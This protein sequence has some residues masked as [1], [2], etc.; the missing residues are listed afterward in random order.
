MGHLGASLH[1]DVAQVGLCELDELLGRKPSRAPFP[2]LV[3]QRVIHRRQEQ[4]LKDELGTLLHGY[5]Q[6]GDQVP[7]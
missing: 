1:F 6:G 2:G 7:P 3:R 5:A 4:R